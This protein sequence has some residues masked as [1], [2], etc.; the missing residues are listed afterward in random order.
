M[1]CITNHL[2][3]P[4]TCNGRLLCRQFCG[5]QLTAFRFYCC[6]SSCCKE[7]ATQAV[8][9]VFTQ[10]QTYILQHQITSFCTTADIHFAATNRWFLHNCKHTLCS[11][12]SLIFAQ[13]QT[14][15]LQQQIASFYASAEIHF[16][17]TNP[18]FLNCRHTLCSNKSLVFKQLQAYTLQQQISNFAHLQTC[19]LQ[20]VSNLVF[21]AQSTSA[22]IF[23]RTLCSN[24]S[25]VFVQLQTY[26]LQQQIAS[27]PWQLQLSL[28]ATAAT[29]VAGAGTPGSRRWERKIMLT[30]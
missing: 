13:V 1:C 7:V 5:L 22:V 23:G 27:L 29:K 12:K 3:A 26:T 6:K 15:T 2:A 28:A 21:Y 25:L 19:T 30:C 8:E 18:Q 10:L 20:Q 9:F 11:N 4:K 17:A 24:K 14:Y 16:A